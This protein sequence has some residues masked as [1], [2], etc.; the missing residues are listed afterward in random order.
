MSHYLRTLVQVL[1]GIA[2]LLALALPAFATDLPPHAVDKASCDGPDN[3][4]SS[5]YFP[6]PGNLHTKAG[7]HTI[8]E[9]NTSNMRAKLCYQHDHG[10]PFP[11]WEVHAP[12]R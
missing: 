12:L 9:A 11:R 2:I 3:V 1:L 7:I 4:C 8:N 10:F 5:L 6:E